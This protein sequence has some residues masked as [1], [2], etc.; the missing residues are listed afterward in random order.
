MTKRAI[1]SPYTP[2][3]LTLVTGLATKILGAYVDLGSAYRE[4]RNIQKSIMP[5]PELQRRRDSTKQFHIDYSPRTRVLQDSYDAS[6]KVAWERT[7]SEAKELAPQIM[8]QISPIPEG[9]NV[10]LSLTLDF[11]SASV[12]ASEGRVYRFSLERPLTAFELEYA[13]RA[14]RFLG[15]GSRQVKKKAEIPVREQVKAQ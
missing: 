8:S 7:E 11:A 4:A 10:D 5:S 14:S 12:S 13:E 9:F 3:E 2:K 15:L 1:V 6:K